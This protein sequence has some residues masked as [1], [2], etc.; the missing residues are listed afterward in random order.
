M[1]GD[2]LPHVS[3]WLEVP[4]DCRMEATLDFGDELRFVFGNSGENRQYLAF[5]RPAL[6]Q[7]VR[8][9]QDALALREPGNVSVDVA[10][11]APEAG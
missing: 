10:H 5:D 4:E 1:Y 11:V 7:F 6:E 8:L 9:A 3:S 2:N